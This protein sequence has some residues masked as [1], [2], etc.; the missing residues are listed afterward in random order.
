[1][2]YNPLR[3]GKFNADIISVFPEAWAFFTRSPREEQIHIYRYKNNKLVEESYQNT[4][5]KCLFGVS[6]KERAKGIE[7]GHLY[8]KALNKKDNWIACD[9][10]LNGCMNWDSIPVLNIINPSYAKEVCGE[11][12]IVSK[13]IVP[14]AWSSS[15]ENIHMPS[16]VIKINALCLK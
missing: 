13:K 10:D 2:P 12:F 14:W 11:Y 1:M 16:K 7:I 8:E 6:K 3:S 15:R 4:S 9:G 5:S